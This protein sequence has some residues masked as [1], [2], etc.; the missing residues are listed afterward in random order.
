M[1]TAVAAVAA[2]VALL[3]ARP[4]GTAVGQALRLRAATDPRVGPE[5]PPSRPVERS[6]PGTAE[7]PAVAFDGTNY[8]VVWEDT[9]RVD[10]NTDIYGARVTPSGA[11][12]DIGGIPIATGPDRQMAPTVA[13]GDGTFFVAWTSH[14]AGSPGSQ[15]VGA[16][17]SPAGTPLD[18]TGFA[19]SPS[20]G[21][22]VQ[23]AAAYG[24]GVF[25]VVWS[26]SAS[27]DA[28]TRLLGRRVNSSGTALGQPIPIG[29]EQDR[30]F[31]PAV[32]FGAGTFLA[33]WSDHRLHPGPLG[34]FDVFAARVSS[35]GSLLDPSP[36]AITTAPGDQANP[37]VAFAGGNFLI[38]WPD[39]RSGDSRVFGARVNLAGAV[40]DPNGIAISVNSS[41]VRPA[42]A[43]QGT[44]FLVSWYGS[45]G[46]ISVFGARIDRTGRNL[47]PSNFVIAPGVAEATYPRAL[48]LGSDGTDAFAVWNDPRLGPGTVHLFGAGVSPAGVVRG[49]G[50]L[51][52]RSS[53]QQRKSAV[54]FDGTNHLVVWGDNRSGDFTDIVAVRV[55]AAGVI[56]DATPIEI[57]AGA[58][59]YDINVVFDGENYLV[60]WIGNGLQAVRVDRSGRVMG[61]PVSLPTHESLSD[62]AIAFN[63]TSFLVTWTE[64]DGRSSIVVRGARL[65]REG[66]ILDPDGLL[67]AGSSLQA[68][69]A[70]DGQNFLVIW[71]DVATGAVRRSLLRADGTV[72]GTPGT[73][74]ATTTTDVPAEPSVAW[75]GQ[76]Y[77]VAWTLRQPNGSSDVVGAR[78]SATGALQGPAGFPIAAL[79][80][81]ASEP[82]VV[83]NGSFLVVWK[84]RRTGRD[85]LHG[86][87]VNDDGALLDTP[88]LLLVPGDG[89]DANLAPGPGATWALTY[90]RHVA[91]TPYGVDRVFVRTVAPK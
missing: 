72:I 23:P 2:L 34:T 78:I 8:L 42:I 88:S 46:M 90:T 20:A 75:N 68:S 55:S 82:V 53:N 14:P 30:Q 52:D 56:L 6:S 38:A 24:D 63:S 49:P 71:W 16:R 86:T 44:G 19:V 54:A 41:E 3:V 76:R 64:Y 83:A 25:L 69:V 37:A 13:F 77:L 39:H 70:S 28:L 62:L 21:L 73:L 57:A 80:G 91:E 60:A 11:V 29:P 51:I 87:R 22:Q 7:V 45:D 10:G 35:T 33:T 5:H 66:T 17:V 18:P 81:D 59:G 31:D 27:P 89:R 4:T 47:D 15:V 85:G 26:D 48:A 9:R 61:P 12:L 65:S 84:E 50:A 32:A 58:G 43:V 40:L 74:I 36:V 79:P 1:L 67:I